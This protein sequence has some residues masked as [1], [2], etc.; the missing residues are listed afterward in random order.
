MNNHSPPFP[1]L[2]NYGHHRLETWTAEDEDGCLFALQYLQR[3]NE[4]VLSAPESTPRILTAAILEE[5][6]RLE[7]LSLHS[8]TAESVLPKQFLAGGVPRLRVVT[9]TG[10][11]LEVLHPLLPSATSLRTLALERISTSAYFSPDRLVSQ[12][13][14]MAQ[15]QTLFISFLSTVPRP[16]FRNKRFLP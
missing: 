14:T 11:S 12:I 13:H 5:A 2:L 9:L 1:L 15:L 8:Q 7:H 10:A 6:P 3:A 16:G 4:I